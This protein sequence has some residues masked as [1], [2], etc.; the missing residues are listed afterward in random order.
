MKMYESK[1]QTENFQIDADIGTFDIKNILHEK[2][3]KRKIDICIVVAYVLLATVMGN[4]H[5]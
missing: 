1:I 4:W 3:E 2:N 5:G